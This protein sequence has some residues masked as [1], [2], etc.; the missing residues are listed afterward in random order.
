[1]AGKMAEKRV[2]SKYLIAAII[3]KQIKNGFGKSC[4]DDTP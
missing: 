4:L 2:V 1:M 3:L